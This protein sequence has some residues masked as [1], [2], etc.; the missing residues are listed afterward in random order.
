MIK[1]CFC[2]SWPALCAKFAICRKKKNKWIALVFM[3]IH[4][5]C[6]FTH[7]RG[8][9]NMVETLYRINSGI[10]LGAEISL[11]KR[12]GCGSRKRQRSAVFWKE[13]NIIYNTSYTIYINI[14]KLY[15]VEFKICDWGDSSS[16]F[17]VREVRAQ[18]Q[19][20]QISSV[21]LDIETPQGHTLLSIYLYSTYIVLSAHQWDPKVLHKAFN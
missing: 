1:Y 11:W 7:K 18:K 9:E 3:I 5:F 19:S 17:K 4:R 6:T 20:G 8:G 12:W 16:T 21:C 14:W 10:R 13:Q 2:A 15:T